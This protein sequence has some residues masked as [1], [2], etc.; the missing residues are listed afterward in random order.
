MGALMS[1]LYS[2]IAFVASLVAVRDGVE[3]SMR[4]GSLADRTFGVFNAIGG[5]DSTCCESHSIR[6][7]AQGS[8]F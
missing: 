6:L 1:A 4:P 7:R 8:G 5:L 2:T 3:Y